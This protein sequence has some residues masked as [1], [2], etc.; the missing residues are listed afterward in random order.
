MKALNAVLLVSAAYAFVSSVFAKALAVR[1]AV[2]IHAVA[3]Q[4]R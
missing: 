1:V 4:I 2:V 3:A